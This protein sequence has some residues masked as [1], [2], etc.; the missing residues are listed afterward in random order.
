M[1]NFL[2]T[3]R[4][5]ERDSCTTSRHEFNWWPK[6]SMPGMQ[7]KRCDQF[8]T[9]LWLWIWQRDINIYIQV[10]LFIYYIIFSYPYS[11]YTGKNIYN[12]WLQNND[13]KYLQMAYYNQHNTWNFWHTYRLEAFLRQAQHYDWLPP[14]SLWPATKKLK[15]FL[16]ESIMTT[17]AI[18]MPLALAWPGRVFRHFSSAIFVFRYFGSISHTVRK[19]PR[20]SD[21]V[22]RPWL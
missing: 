12:M 1:P 8:F 7:I 16:E 13:C 6:A 15:D 9:R 10:L 20:S 21:C 18:W 3:W 17:L 4:C 11:P 14:T 5:R 2:K 22:A 19:M